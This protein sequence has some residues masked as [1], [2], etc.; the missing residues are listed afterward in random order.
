VQKKNDH[1]RQ[2]MVSL[3]WSGRAPVH[4]GRHRWRVWCLSCECRFVA[5]NRHTE[6]CS[7]KCRDAGRS[8]KRR[9]LRRQHAWSLSRRCENCLSR[10]A[11]MNPRRR[12]C[13]DAC[14]GR[15]WRVTRRDVAVRQA[16]CDACGGVIEKPRA[17]RRFCSDV[18]R[19]TAWR[20]RG[21]A[22]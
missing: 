18:C 16:A 10:F 19:V 14:Q 5:G 20:G 11:S 6:Y 13:C 8:L 4:V 12:F 7:Q 22:S 1:L 2:A 21:G 3:A 15:A 17:R 9:H